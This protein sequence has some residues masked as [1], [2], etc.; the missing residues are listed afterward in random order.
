MRT[1]TLDE[2]PLMLKIDEYLSFIFENNPKIS[3]FRMIANS[4]YLF[5]AIFSFLS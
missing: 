1:V 4:T 3:P 2:T 5:I